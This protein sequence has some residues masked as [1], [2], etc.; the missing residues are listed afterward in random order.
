MS[1]F[2]SALLFCSGA[3]AVALAAPPIDV[4]EVPA[5]SDVGLDMVQLKAT[6]SLLHYFTHSLAP[7]LTM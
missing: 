4:Q 2:L 1:V 7:H 3:I 5:D 6:P